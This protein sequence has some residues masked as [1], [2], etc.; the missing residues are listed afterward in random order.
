MDT[1]A[2]SATTTATTQTKATTQG[3][4]DLG[5]EDFFKLLITELQNQDPTKPMDNQQLMSELSTIRQM[6]QTSTL[7]ST[8]QTLAAQERFGTTTGLIGQY[9]SGTV[10]NDAGDSFEI[11]GLVI[12]VR[13]DSKGEAVLELH[14][15]QALPAS[16]V[17][18]VTVVENLPADLQE[19]LQQ[20]LAE[21]SG[22]GDSA[23]ARSIASGA[24]NAKKAASATAAGDKVRVLAQKTDTT[25]NMVDALL[26]SGVGI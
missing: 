23:A 14:D 4:D 6:Q 16:K 20:E 10:T 15:G 3:F 17:E 22:S 21:T 19:Q 5:S 8:L 7:N 18:Q 25:A 1:S 12:G 24:T 2:V 26:A 11:Q 13:F 9:V